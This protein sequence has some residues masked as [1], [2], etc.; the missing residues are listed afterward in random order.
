MLR[1]RTREPLRRPPKRRR[2]ESLD[3]PVVAPPPHPHGQV[4]ELQ[5]AAG[6][7]AVGTIL[8]Q[9]T[10]AAPKPKTDEE[11]WGEDWNDVAF[12]S[13]KKHF[14]GTDRP[15]GTAKE[16][17]DVLCPLYRQ[18]GIKRPLK[19]VHDNIVGTRFFGHFTYAHRDLKSAL[20]DAEKALKAKG[21]KDAP[22][23]KCWAFNPRTTSEGNWS[24]HADGKAIDID[25]DTNPRLIRKQERDVISALTGIDVSAPYPGK[26]MGV[27]SYQGSQF[28]SGLFQVMYGPR[29]MAFKIAVLEQVALDQIT[30]VD[31]AKTE[32]AGVPTGKKATA[33]D[34]KRR[35]EI[36]KK[37]KALEALLAQTRGMQKVLT[38]EKA[39][40]EKL[41]TDMAALEAEIARLTKELEDLAKE[42]AAATTKKAKAPLV[43]AQSAKKKR[44]AKALEELGA[45]RADPLRGYAD[46][47]FLDLNPDL[48]QALKDAGLHWGGEVWAGKD[49]MHFQ[50]APQ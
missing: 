14:E 41:D 22:F 48:V 27:D 2:D 1:R 19:Y 18:Q 6:N 5:R 26:D 28:A 7:Q 13:A 50:V 11:Q 4:L 31:A 42:L 9:P 36:A 43:K 46:K 24:N 30:D 3:E 15:K 20:D 21:Y 47:G 39:R 45:K 17:Y 44:L 32:L 25:E 16:R 37:V 34:K 49:Y 12:A 29:G 23:R 40:Y 10:V 33:D 35:K 38:T 8:R